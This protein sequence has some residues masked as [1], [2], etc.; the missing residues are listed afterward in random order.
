MRRQVVDFMLLDFI[1]SVPKTSI[2]MGMKFREG[3][4][5]SDSNETLHAQA[6]GYYHTY[7]QS[8]GL[9]NPSIFRVY[10]SNSEII[11][12]H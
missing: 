2:L 10:P 11:R 3:A 7:C 8:K 9:N 1:Y 12:F 4:H 6:S 5:Q